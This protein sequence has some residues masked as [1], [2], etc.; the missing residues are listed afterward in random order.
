MKGL[1]IFVEQILGQQQANRRDPGL[2]CSDWL[3][4]ENHM[5]LS[6]TTSLKHILRN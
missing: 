2:V 1:E 6:S 4:T 5:H 3:T